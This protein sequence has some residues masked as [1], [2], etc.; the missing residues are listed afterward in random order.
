MRVGPLY[1]RED[2]ADVAWPD[3]TARLEK[4]LGAPKTKSDTEW[5]WAV[6]DGDTCHTLK[7][8]KQGDQDKVSGASGGKV[9]SVI[10]EPFDKCK[11]LAAGTP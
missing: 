6:V 1:L 8:H 9:S 11:K 5:V 3:T 2:V 7:L 10:T 4:E